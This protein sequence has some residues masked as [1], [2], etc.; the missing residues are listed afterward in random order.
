MLPVGR[1]SVMANKRKNPLL[2]VE[3]KPS[4]LSATAEEVFAAFRAMVIGISCPHCAEPFTDAAVDWGDAWCEG[5]RDT[6]AEC[7]TQ[8]RDGPYKVKC[9]LCGERSWI[10]Y[11]AETASK[12]RSK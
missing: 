8:E 5:R 11:F 6:L 4:G 7:D 1:H 2:N 9:E 10:N 3:L 12:T